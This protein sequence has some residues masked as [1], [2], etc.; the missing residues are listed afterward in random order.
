ML[1]ANPSLEAFDAAMAERR[2][3]L[4]RQRE[5]VKKGTKKYKELTAKIKRLPMGA[6]QKGRGGTFKGTF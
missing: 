2:K 1:L 6:V 4:E 3:E 5:G